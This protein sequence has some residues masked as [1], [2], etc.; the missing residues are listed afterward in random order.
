MEHLSVLVS[1]RVLAVAI[2]VDLVAPVAAADEPGSF[3]DLWHRA[4][5]AC[6]RKEA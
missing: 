2:V 1:P 6:A 5:G 4:A 3:D